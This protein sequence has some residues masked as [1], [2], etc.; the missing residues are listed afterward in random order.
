MTERV[1]IVVKIAQVLDVART[2]ERVYR[3]DGYRGLAGRILRSFY[4]RL[5]TDMLD[6]PLLLDDVADSGNLNL[7]SVQIKPSSGSPLTVGWLTTPPGLGSGGHTTMFRM[8]T[9]LEEA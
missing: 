7:Q 2:A 8:I 4:D 6:F 1:V 3:T 9:A 5:G